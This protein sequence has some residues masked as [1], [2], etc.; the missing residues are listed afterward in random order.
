M[1]AN[2]VLTLT[3]PDRIG[4][5]EE[6]TRVLLGLEGNIENSRMVHLGGEFA[7]LALVS[8]PEVHIV[9]LERAFAQMVGQGYKLTVT[10]TEKAEPVAA[11]QYRIEVE[12]AD[13]EGI[14][15]G[16]ARAISQ[17]GI[18]IE[19]MDTA[20]SEA[21]VSGAPLF[22]MNALVAVPRD[23]TGPDWR[24]ELSAA[25]ADADVDLSITAVGE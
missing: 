24:A 10:A 15:N 9:A 13:H 4:V 5:V 23:L 21:P 1:R 18:S 19:T 2:I 6:A 12:G 17:L 22:S 11:A 16:I 25:A 7:I 20:T 3:G 8:L 14:I